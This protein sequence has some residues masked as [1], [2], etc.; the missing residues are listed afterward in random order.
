MSESPESSRLSTDAAVESAA[1][2]WLVRHDRGLSAEQQDAFLQW[3][4]VSPAHRESFQRHRRMWGDFNALAQW[5]PEHSGAPNPDLLAEPRRSRAL[6]WVAPILAMAAV[7]A[8]GVWW[9]AAPSRSVEKTL[10]FE[11]VNYRQE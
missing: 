9:S 4:A 11:A 7:V 3:L 2:E 6:R 1:A 8:F 5:R 10:A